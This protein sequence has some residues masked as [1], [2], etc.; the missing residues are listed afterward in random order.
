MRRRC[1]RKKDSWDEGGVSEVM[2]T[3]LILAITVV[4]F[5][6]II[7]WVGSFP[8]PT[9]SVRLT[10]R[11]ELEGIMTGGAWTGAVIRI[12]HL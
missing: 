7:I 2:G 9:S 5:S 12:T 8:A 6:V 3:I 1:I 10:M 11:G 4:L